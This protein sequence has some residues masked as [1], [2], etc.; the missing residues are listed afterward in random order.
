MVSTKELTDVADQAAA[1][2]IA[3]RASDPQGAL[4]QGTAIA[5]LRDIAVSLR[6]IAQNTLTDQPEKDQ[7]S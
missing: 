3:Q 1:A 7:T 5:L 6:Q 2:L 4:F